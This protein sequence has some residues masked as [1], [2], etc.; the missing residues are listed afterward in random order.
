MKLL[1]LVASAFPVNRKCKC[2]AVQTFC[3]AVNTTPCFAHFQAAGFKLK[4]TLSIMRMSYERWHTEGKTESNLFCTILLH[5]CCLNNSLRK[6]TFPCIDLIP[7]MFTCTAK[8]YCNGFVMCIEQTICMYLVSFARTDIHNICQFGVRIY[9]LCEFPIYKR[10]ALKYALLMES[11]YED[12]II[13]QN[14][15]HKK[16][17][18]SKYSSVNSTLMR[19]L[20]G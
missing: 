9:S 14:F 15:A 10:H 20:S 2:S 19:W 17:S 3:K 18:N 8:P 13:L 16:A 7:C 11:D 6:N 5:I 1:K 4:T 12:M